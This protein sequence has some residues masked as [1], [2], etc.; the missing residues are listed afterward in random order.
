MNPF[1][2]IRFFQV[3]KQRRKAYA[4][5]AVSMALAHMS[6]GMVKYRS[7]GNGMA[8]ISLS[9]EENQNFRL[10]FNPLALENKKPYTMKGT[11]EM[12][13]DQYLLKFATLKADLKHLFNHAAGISNKPAVINKKTVAIPQNNRGIMIYGIYCERA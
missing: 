3:K 13:G 9:L 12:E 4:S 8:D 7:V 11:W 5:L 6:L 1:R 10:D 2:L